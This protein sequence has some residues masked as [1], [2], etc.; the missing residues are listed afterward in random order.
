MLL[1]VSVIESLFRLQLITYLQ[2]VGTT[3]LITDWL[4]TIQDEVVYIWQAPWNRGTLLFFLTRYP[5]FADSALAVYHHVTY[6]LSEDQCANLFHIVGW[7]VGFGIWTSELIYGILIQALYGRTL[8]VR[9]VVALVWL[10]GVVAS[11]T[12]FESFQKSQ[13][14][15]AMDIIAPSIPGC[16]TGGGNNTALI[17]A[18]VLLF[19]QTVALI[20]TVMKAI[21]HRKGSTTSLLRI[22]FKDGIIYYL[23][24]QAVAVAVWVTFAVHI[25]EYIN[26]AMGLQRSMHSILSARIL[27]NLRYEASKN[28]VGGGISI[29]DEPIDVIAFTPGSGEWSAQRDI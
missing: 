8:K 20:L 3:L 29:G 22:F 28:T 16:Y 19:N 11:I 4:L 17:P 24:L 12:A 14:F 18:S 26:L 6:G 5:A 25:H 1:D 23:A 21:Q 27:L 7:M 13:T 2:L 15:V 9:L 10:S